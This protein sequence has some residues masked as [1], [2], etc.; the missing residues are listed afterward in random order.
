M[1]WGNSCQA[2]NLFILQ[3]KECHIEHF[4]VNFKNLKILPFPCCFILESLVYAKKCLEQRIIKH[5]YDDYLT[6]NRD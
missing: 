5:N 6:R 1:V 4:K 3:K 2:G